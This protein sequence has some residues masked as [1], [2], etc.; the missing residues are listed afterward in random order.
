M[1]NI[2]QLNIK[3]RRLITEINENKEMEIEEKVTKLKEIIP[4]FKVIKECRDRLTGDLY[5]CF[6]YALN[7]PPVKETKIFRSYHVEALI[8]CGVLI[9]ISENEAHDE[10]IIV[11]FDD[12]GITKHAGKKIGQRVISKWGN[13]DL[14]EHGRAAVPVE[15]GTVLKFYKDVKEPPD[16]LWSMAT[17]AKSVKTQKPGQQ[18]GI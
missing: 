15:Y 14:Y 16:E 3:V 1:I 7:V 8:K 18:L 12:F 2:N 4:E 9:E 5:N 6:S 13:M 11:Y 17:G 10:D